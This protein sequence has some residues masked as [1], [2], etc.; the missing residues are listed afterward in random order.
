VG[1]DESMIELRTVSKR[2]PA[3]AGDAVTAVSDISFDVAQGQFTVLIGPSGCGKSTL[4]RL[5]G[6]LTPSTTGTVLVGGTPVA[7][8]R[9]DTG[10]VF[11]R[12][13]LLEWMTVRDNVLVSA[14]IN[15]DLTD[16]IRARADELLTI[17]GIADFADR[18]PSTLSGGMQQRAGIA[19]ALL[20]DPE[21]LLLD[22]PFGALDALTREQLN[23]ELLRIWSGAAATDRP[24][25]VR[26]TVVMVTHDIPEAVF[27]SDR[28]VVM[29]ARPGTVLETVDVPLPRP[30]T[31]DMM[32]TPEFGA[33]VQHLRAELAPRAAAAE[34]GSGEPSAEVATR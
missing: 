29:S 14:K 16:D 4:L 20:R 33:L 30:R 24:D 13:L 21:L 18:L 8:P 25:P 6:G 5:I 11:Q 31:L 10:F 34:G 15:R 3:R 28:I 2:F 7:G 17:M 12:P 32:F 22:E 1:S 27:L 26:K 23:L 9:A 19:R